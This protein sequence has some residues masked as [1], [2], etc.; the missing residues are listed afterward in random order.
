MERLTEKIEDRY[1]ARLDRLNGKIVGNQM[2]LNKLG[3]YENAEEKGLLVKLPC[4]IGAD[5]Y[6][7]PSKVN[8]DLNILNNH[9]ECNK[10]HHQNV[11]QITY[12]RHGWYLECD[13]DIEFGTGGIFLDKMFG[14]T[15]FLT[16]EAAEQKLEELSN[17]W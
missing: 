14:E 17:K 10:V 12:T 5:I 4:G 15:W 6:Y 3:E 9:R 8:F 1:I 2:C 7:V 16:S 11:A 13:K